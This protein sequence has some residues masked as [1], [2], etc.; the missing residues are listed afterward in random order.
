MRQIRPDLWETRTDAPFPGLT[1]HAYLW[2][3]PGDGNVLV[4]NTA[5]DDDLEQIARLGGVAH[6]YLS[7][8][9]EV[10][11]MLATYRRRFGAVLHAPA[12]EADAV[13]K[14]QAPDVTFAERHVDANGIEVVPTP[15]HTPGSTCYLVPGA[16]GLT[17]LFTGDTLF[18]DTKGRW[19][20]G[21]LPGSDAEALLASLDLLAGLEP[22]VVVSS[23]FTGDVGAHVLGDTPWA[24][25]VAEARAGLESELARP[26]KLG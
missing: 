26:S 9:D 20:A 25:C 21:N 16:D 6:Q 3:P 22:D 5:G 10:A 13:A 19:R 4:Y 8:E 1:T 7:H 14:V 17:Y 18:T 24:D 12:V 23:A 2:T 15:G 11:P